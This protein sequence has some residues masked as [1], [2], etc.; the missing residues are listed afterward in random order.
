[1]ATLSAVTVED[2]LDYYAERNY[3]F[4]PSYGVG[5]GPGAMVQEL[6]EV[7]PEGLRWVTCG[8][9]AHAGLKA[10]KTIRNRGRILPA[11]KDACS[12]AACGVLSA[13]DGDKAGNKG[14]EAG[15]LTI[16]GEAS[17]PAGAGRT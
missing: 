3:S 6:I 15:S 2:I 5:A 1:M 10:A 7:L 17:S 9:I 12:G 16:H 14:R 4:R 13:N 11:R 8:H